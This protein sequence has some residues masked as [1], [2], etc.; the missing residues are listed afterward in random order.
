MEYLIVIFLNT[1]WLTEGKVYGVGA[2]HGLGVDGPGA[3][4]AVYCLLPR[5]GTTPGHTRQLLKGQSHASLL[6]VLPP[7]PSWD[8]SWI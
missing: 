7:P 8:N 4:S 5:G 6:R 3:S 2:E 1:Y